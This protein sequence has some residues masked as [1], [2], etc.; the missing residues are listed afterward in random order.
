ME[1]APSLILAL[2]AT[3]T[4][5]SMWMRMASAMKLKLP[6]VRILQHVIMTPRL[7]I[8][9]I[10]ITQTQVTIVLEIAL[11]MPIV[12]AF[13]MNL[14]LR[15]ARH[16]KRATSWQRPLMKMEAALSPSLA[17]TVMETACSMW[18]RTVFVTKRKQSAVKM[19]KPATSIQQRQTR[20]I[21][22]I[23]TQAMIVRAFAL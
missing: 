15:V 22:I 11:Q 8:Q 19:L 14:K 7:Q 10:A 21:A 20:V 1:V 12:M 2:T 6:V 5:C 23:Q 9:A 16:L 4:A 3:E 13:A 18:T 17:L